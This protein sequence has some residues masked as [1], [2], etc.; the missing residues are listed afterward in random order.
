MKSGGKLGQMWPKSKV[1]RYL[2]EVEA[3][4]FVFVCVQTVK[5]LCR[6][7]NKSV[8]LVSF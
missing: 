6:K 8:F 4:D 3:D 2:E 7:C 1:R 5:G